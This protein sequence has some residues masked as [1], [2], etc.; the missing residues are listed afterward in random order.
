MKPRFLSTPT[1]LIS[2]VVVMGSG[3]LHSLVVANEQPQSVHYAFANYLGSGIYGSTGNTAA[4]V[5]IPLSFDLSQDDTSK[6]MLRLPFSVGFANYQW[7]QIPDLEL[8]DTVGSMT[9]TPGIE[10]HW[11]ATEQLKMEAYGDL[12]YGHNFGDHTNVGIISLGVS[13]LYSFGPAELSPLWVS[14]FY[15]AGYRD[16]ESGKGDSYSALRT[17]V[18]MGLGLSFQAWDRQVDP[19]VFAAMHWFFNRGQLADDLAGALMHD[20]TLETGISLAFD[21]PVGIDPITLDRVGVSY[22]RVEG[23]DV[24]RL[25]FSLPI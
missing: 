18:D 7:D 22:S 12:G 23:E 24:W 1:R 21:R 13:T 19:R 9:L 15:S 2:A 5:N 17:G 10:Y 11:Q 8:P 20:T 6:L 4:V 25:F 16:L 3:L 14:R